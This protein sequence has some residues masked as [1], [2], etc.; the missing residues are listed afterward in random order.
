[1]SEYWKLAQL[2]ENVKKGSGSSQAG[3]GVVIETVREGE[4]SRAVLCI[5]VLEA[6]LS[7]GHA[8]EPCELQTQDT[9]MSH[10]QTGSVCAI[11]T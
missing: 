10:K 5:E 9:P 6:S 7:H 3:G 11:F 8:C 2:F 4:Y 1:M